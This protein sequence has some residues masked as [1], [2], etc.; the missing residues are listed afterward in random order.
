MITKTCV[1][2]K[3]CATFST[4]PRLLSRM[5]FLM[6]IKRGGMTKGFATYSTFIRFLPCMNSLMYIKIGVIA[7]SFAT[8]STYIRL[9]PRMNYQMLLKSSTFIKV[10][11]ALISSLFIMWTLVI[12]EE[13]KSFKEGSNIIAHIKLFPITYSDTNLHPP[14]FTKSICS[15]RQVNISPWKNNGNFFERFAK[16]NNFYLHFRKTYILAIFDNL[17][18]SY[19]TSFTKLFAQWTSWLLWYSKFYFRE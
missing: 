14:T 2:D 6:C 11:I 10:I 8:F 3:G 19:I 1:A 18:K 5:N 17:I 15:E 4:F 16:L 7:K 9:F 12:I 13:I